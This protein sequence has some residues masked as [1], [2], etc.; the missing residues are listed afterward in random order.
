[1]SFGSLNRCRTVIF[2]L[3]LVCLSKASA[4]DELLSGLYFSSHEVIQDK[5]TSLNLTPLDYFRFS[6]QFTLEFEAN[7]RKGDGYYGYIFRLLGDDTTNIDL[8]SNLASTTSNFWLV[9][10]EQ[11]LLSFK[12]DQL[13]GA[14]YDE[15]VKIKFDI[16]LPNSCASL[17]INDVKQDVT[18]PTSINTNLFNIVFGALHLQ[19]FVSVDVC[20][21]SLKN[22][23]IYNDGELCRYWSLSEHS[24][25]QVFD[26]VKNAEA[27]V[28]NPNWIIDRH[29]KWKKVKE[30]EMEGIMGSSHDTRNRRIFFINEKEIYCI[31]LDSLVVDTIPFL[32]SKPYNEKLA[33]QIIYNEYFDQLWSYDFDNERINIFNFD[34]RTWSENSNTIVESLYAHQNRFISP[35][36]S[37][38]IT[39]SGYGHYTYSSIV[40]HYNRQTQSWEMIDRKD[41]IGPR[42]LSGSTVMN[43]ETAL[44]FGGYGSQTG[45]QE[46]SPN[47]YYDLY[48]FDLNNYT[49]RKIWTLPTPEIPFVPIETLV[50]DEGQNCFYTLVYNNMH[51]NT[52][53]RL[54]RFNIDDGEYVIYNDSIPYNFLDIDSWTSLFMNTKSSELITYI[55]TGSKVEI[56]SIAYPPRLKKDILQK[57]KKTKYGSQLYWVTVILVSLMCVFY[58]YKRNRRRKTTP[59][60]EVPIDMNYIELIVPP[61]Q[62]KSASIY[63]LGTFKIIDSD[64]SDITSN[65]APTTTQLFLLMLMNTIK[66]G[67]GTTSQELKN[68]LWYDKDDN[69]A[70]NNRNVYINKLRIILKSFEK[71]KII[72]DDGYQTIQGLELVFCDY[73][74]V[75]ALIN[76]LKNNPFFNKQVFVELVDLALTGTL[77]PLCQFEWLESHQTEYANLIIDTLLRF[78][79]HAEVKS[80]LILLVKM[81]DTILLHDNIDEDAI[82][83]KC[84]A[85]F[86]MGHKKQALDSFNKFVVD[87]ESLLAEKTK[88]T[89]EDLIK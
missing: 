24:N 88:L 84:Y 40:H 74:R 14:G 45:Q 80:D 38:L 44:I 59:H 47:F 18:F 28:S 15:W 54:A 27:S 22:V 9:Y 56:F 50:Y 68:I 35:V 75:Q 3:F 17:S 46:L 4:Q 60:Y 85:L 12:W 64:G 67:K 51:H 71:I 21:M 29:V 42:Y 26:E 8:V 1:M 72:N 48:Y 82:S 16:D 58:I 55:T 37:S 65:F 78:K 19:H 62:N 2:L 36:D 52:N 23:R 6:N 20:P 61:E 76:L 7:F 70:R 41:Q 49:F 63:L 89:F 10:K 53:L 57:T 79:D 32:G 33:R 39:I 34:T 66:N 13:K 77:L 25:D 81:A 86:H 5:R 31:Y 87:Y 43:N 83:I 73:V 30:F 69:S 11:T